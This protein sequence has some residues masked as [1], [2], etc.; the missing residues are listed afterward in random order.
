MLVCVVSK[1][2]S[3]I[4]VSEEVFVCVFELMLVVG[5]EVIIVSDILG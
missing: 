5:E 2:V 4:N 3:T 1:V